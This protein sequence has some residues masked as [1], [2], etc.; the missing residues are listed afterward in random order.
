[1]A[2]RSRCIV[3]TLSIHFSLLTPS[4]T[5]HMVRLHN[6]VAYYQDSGI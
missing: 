3:G 2:R 1:L 4:V 5:C 6:F